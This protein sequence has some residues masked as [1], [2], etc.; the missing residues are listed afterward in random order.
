M[1]V[2]SA[3]GDAPAPTTRRLVQPGPPAPDRLQCV[4]A[5]LVEIEAEIAPGT[6]LGDGV[7]KVLEPEGITAGA[8]HFDGLTLDPMRYVQPTYAKTPEHV[9]FYSDV[10]A[11][12]SAH[13]IEFARAT[14]GSVDGK[15]LLHC[16]AL[17]RDAD[18]G[19]QGGHILPF[20]AVVATPTTIRVFGTRDAGMVASPDAETNFTIFNAV[21][22]G[23]AD[24]TEPAR[25]MLVAKIRPNEDLV[26]AIEEICR[27][28]NVREGVILGGI[29]STVGAQFD[30]RPLIP[31]APT[32]IV[33]REGRIAPDP[34]GIPRLSMETALIDAQGRLHVGTLTRGENPVLIC[35]ELFIDVLDG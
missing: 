15:P 19:L 21:P 33:V 5:G 6:A 26:T 28:Q 14:Y 31:E 27:R 29:G 4:R 32:E 8:V 10:R 24:G 3:A 17:W 22:T 11:P 34:A 1:T 2:L 16:H 30:G 13:E 12:D 9:A 23:S 18:G 20:E 25:R 35:V 7:S